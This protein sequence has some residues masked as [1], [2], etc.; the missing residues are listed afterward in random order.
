VIEALVVQT[1][2]KTYYKAKKQKHSYK[3]AKSKKKANEE[4]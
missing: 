1:V 4:V 2:A 3:T